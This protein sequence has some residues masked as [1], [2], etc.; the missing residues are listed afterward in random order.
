[1]PD[2]VPPEVKKDRVHRMQQLADQKAAQFHA[3][4]IGRK[5][6]VLFREGLKTLISG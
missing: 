3:G 2:Q 5:V 1:M 6:E 4:F